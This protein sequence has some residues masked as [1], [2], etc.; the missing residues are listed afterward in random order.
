MEITETLQGA[1]FSQPVIKSKM[2][3]KRKDTRML[4]LSLKLLIFN[5]SLTRWAAYFFPQKYFI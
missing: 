4:L 3:E 1:E 2:I 5:W